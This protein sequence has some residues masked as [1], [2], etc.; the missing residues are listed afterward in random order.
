M[1]QPIRQRARKRRRERSTGGV[2]PKAEPELVARVEVGEVKCYA[3]RE[4]RF[5]GADEEA[6]GH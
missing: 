6:R 3:G 1:D 4:G 5:K 2:Y